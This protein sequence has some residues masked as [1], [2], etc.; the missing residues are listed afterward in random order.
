MKNHQQRP[1]CDAKA[2]LFDSHPSMNLT[3][4]SVDANYDLKALDVSSIWLRG[5]S[6]LLRLT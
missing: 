3:F 2:S 6:A 4:R 1:S 5:S